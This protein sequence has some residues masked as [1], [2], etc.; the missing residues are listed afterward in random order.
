MLEYD[1]LASI[2][3][4]CK[5]RNVRVVLHGTNDFPEDIMTK[6]I[7]GGV[8]KINVNK[9]VLDDYNEYLKVAAPTTALT[10]LME[11]GVDKVVALTET[12]MHRCGSAGKA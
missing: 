7:K 1:R 9:L 2:Y 11:E 5:K 8:S 10:K 6:C 3:E 4:F 12:W